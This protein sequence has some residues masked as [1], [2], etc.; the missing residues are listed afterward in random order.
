MREDEVSAQRIE[1]NYRKKRNERIKGACEALR[2]GL[3]YEECILAQGIYKKSIPVIGA[4]G[5]P[6]K[7]LP[8]LLDFYLPVMIGLEPHLSPCRVLQ[9]YRFSH[10]LIFNSVDL[11][12]AIKITDRPVLLVD[13]PEQSIFPALNNAP[14]SSFMRL[15]TRIMEFPWTFHVTYKDER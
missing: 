7:Y 12:N 4:I 1:N 13:C 15:A 10:L 2:Q 11:G 14:V 6:G 8:A 9:K 3:D 5:N